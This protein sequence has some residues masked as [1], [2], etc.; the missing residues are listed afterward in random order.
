MYD[1]FQACVNP[2]QYRE[3]TFFFHTPE[4]VALPFGIRT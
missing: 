2:E 1:T 4:N 3:N